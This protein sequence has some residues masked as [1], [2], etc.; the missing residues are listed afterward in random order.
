M[1]VAAGKLPGETC[2]IRAEVIHAVRDEMAVHLEDVVFRR[3][4]LGTAGSP[5]D[6]AL[7]ECARLM[8]NELGWTD[9]RSNKE[10]ADVRARFAWQQE[11]SAALDQR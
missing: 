5:G 11:R 1:S 4:E 2:V 10:L 7:R 8:A 3:T 9:E 6:E